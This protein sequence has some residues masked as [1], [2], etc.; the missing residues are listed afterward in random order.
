MLNRA[1]SNL[2]DPDLLASK[3]YT[4]NNYTTFPEQRFFD[5]AEYSMTAGPVFR[6]KASLYIYISTIYPMIS[7][8]LVEKLSIEHNNR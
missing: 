6:R 3:L 7:F 4:G 8:W 1:S 2:F 5:F